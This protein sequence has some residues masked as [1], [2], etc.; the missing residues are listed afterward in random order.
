MSRSQATSTYSTRTRAPHQPVHPGLPLCTEISS[1]H[2]ARA[3]TSV[4]GLQCRSIPE[5]SLES[6]GDSTAQAS[7]KPPPLSTAPCHLGFGALNFSPAGRSRAPQ[8]SL[9]REASPTRFFTG[10]HKKPSP[11]AHPSLPG[12]AQRGRVKEKKA[13]ARSQAG[14]GYCSLGTLEVATGEGPPPSV[15]I[16]DSLS[17]RPLCELFLGRPQDQDFEFH[18]VFGFVPC[19]NSRAF[20]RKRRNIQGPTDVRGSESLLSLSERE[21]AGGSAAPSSPSVPQGLARGE[22]GA[23]LFIVS[24]KSPH[25]THMAP[26]ARRRKR[27][28]R[29]KFYLR[30]SMYLSGQKGSYKNKE[31]GLGETCL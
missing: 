30:G 8:S 1:L 17:P 3:H 22:K 24:P 31:V 9:L 4:Q 16:D 26:D 2:P 27:L 5:K 6:L 12:P 14:T 19:E 29:R 25:L 10:F 18:G 11:S 15:D 13:D 7:P 21:D 28:L 23:T 20:W